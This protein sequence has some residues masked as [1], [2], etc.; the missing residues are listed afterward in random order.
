MYRWKKGSIEIKATKEKDGV[1]AEILK[2]EN[3]NPYAEDLPTCFVL[4]YWNTDDLIFV[5]NRFFKYVPWYMVGTMYK[6][7]KEVQKIVEKANEEN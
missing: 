6:K 5:G 4:A 2:W 7:I 1:S 3:D